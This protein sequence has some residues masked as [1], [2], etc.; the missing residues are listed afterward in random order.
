VVRRKK[1]TKPVKAERTD[2]EDFEAEIDYM[3]E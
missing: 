3:E 2:P 1:T